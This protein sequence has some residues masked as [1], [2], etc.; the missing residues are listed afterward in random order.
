MKGFLSVGSVTPASS[1]SCQFLLASLD[2]RKA[3]GSFRHYALM[4]EIEQE[5]RE[6][7]AQDEMRLVQDL[8]RNS[9]MDNAFR[10]ATFD[11]YRVDKDNDRNLKLCKRYAERFDEMLKKNMGLMFYGD[12][13]TGKS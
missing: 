1:V 8:K 11:N 4:T 10:E 7:Q 6:R 3:R 2:K 9:L 13:G 12:V 5:K